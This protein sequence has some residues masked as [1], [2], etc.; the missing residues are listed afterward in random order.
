VGFLLKLIPGGKTARLLLLG[1]VAVLGFW[2]YHWVSSFVHRIDTASFET[3]TVSLA[4]T[5]AGEEGYTALDINNV[6]PGANIYT[7]M[8]V[9]NS[10]GAAFRYSM[11]STASGDSGLDGDLR[12]SIAAVQDGSCDASAF[13]S[14]MLLEGE[15]AGLSSAAI[16][17][18][19]LAAGATDYLC[20]HVRLPLTVPRKI[21]ARDA[22]TTLNFTAQQ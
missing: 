22:Q 3:S 4:L 10:G 1:G 7:G 21:L 15:R 19:P 14:G 12:V 5:Q 9:D 6:W 18:R 11:V 13:A 17:H 8:D 20:F 2:A 16:A